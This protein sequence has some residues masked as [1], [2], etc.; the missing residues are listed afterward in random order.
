[1][2]K[3]VLN[4]LI[5]AFTITTHA[6]VK[7]PKPS[8]FSKL[9]QKVG[10]TDVTVEYSRPGIKGRKIFGDLVPY[11]KVW[12]TGANENTKVTFS[13]DVI[14]DGKTL[15]KGTYALY[16]KPNKKAWEVIFYTDA[17]NWGTP[18]K[19]DE[20]KVALK[21]SATIIPMPVNVET[22]TITID[23]ITNN[24]ALLGMLWEK[25]Y[26]GVKFETP[27]DKSV[28]ETITKTM[29]NSTAKEG[30]YYEA[31]VYYLNT[32]GKDI[33]K[34][35]QWIDKAVSLTEK[36]PRFWYIHQQALIH[37]KAGNKKAAKKAA[38]R[39]LEL[40]KKAKYDAYIKKNKDLLKTL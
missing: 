8:P 13:S 11:D 7:T 20:S 14:F 23:D 35:K 36:E 40:A 24:S 32:K 17:K 5:I 21:T 3:I 34:A 1:M 27:T 10:L 9:E 19:W 38:K 18:K 26:V 39:S 6:Q 2:K 37:A 31:A 4:L 12:R 16:T 30:D 28:E 29:S 25:A 22:F 33:N 15:K